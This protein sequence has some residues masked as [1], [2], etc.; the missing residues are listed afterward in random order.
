MGFGLQPM[1]MANANR[2]VAMTACLMAAGIMAPIRGGRQRKSD[3]IRGHVATVPE[4]GSVELAQKL[5]I[6]REFCCRC[7]ATTPRDNRLFF[8]ETTL[9]LWF[10]VACRPPRAQAGV[11]AGRASSSRR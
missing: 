3:G 1:V 6:S 5:G 4:R 9:N 7:G 8:G 10:G 2:V 11:G